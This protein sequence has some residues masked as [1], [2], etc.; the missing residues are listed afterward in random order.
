MIGLFVLVG[1]LTVTTGADV[2]VTAVPNRR[3][4]TPYNSPADDGAGSVVVGG[5]PSRSIC[6]SSIWYPS[7]HRIAPYNVSIC[8]NAVS[9]RFRKRLSSFSTACSLLLRSLRN[10]YSFM[11][12]SLLL[13]SLR[14]PSSGGSSRSD[15]GNFSRLMPSLAI[16]QIAAGRSSRISS[17]MRE[18]HSSASASAAPVAGVR[19]RSPDAARAPVRRR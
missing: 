7:R 12:G 10:P 2:P 15:G 9:G 19:C 1:P 18:G 4:C 8:S 3:A 11:A 14:N 13:R 16:R 17:L 6:S 5:T